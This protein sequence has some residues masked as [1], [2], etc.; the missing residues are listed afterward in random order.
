M[1][2]A[3]YGR[4]GTPNAAN[5][6]A[7]RENSGRKSP[8]CMQTLSFIN[9]LQVDADAAL[10]PWQGKFDGVQDI[11]S[12]R[13]ISTIVIYELIISDGLASYDRHSLWQEGREVRP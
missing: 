7:V 8:L 4:A 5:F 12:E 9:P 1:Q 11:R 13:L 3:V 10:T 6:P 2:P